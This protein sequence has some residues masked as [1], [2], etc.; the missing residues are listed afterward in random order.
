L[1]TN[2]GS[3]R[4]TVKGKDS[5]SRHVLIMQS[6]YQYDIHDCSRIYRPREGSYG[7]AVPEC[8]EEDQNK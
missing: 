8:I 6:L 5:G 4:V 1:V 7:I 3:K 2:I